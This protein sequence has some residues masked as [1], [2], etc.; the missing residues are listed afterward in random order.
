MLRC[1]IVDDSS[2]FLTQAG[3]L[4]ESQGARVVGV[5]ATS[6]EAIRQVREL[7]PDVTLLD[8]HLGADSGFDLAR[9]LFLEAGV[10][11]GRMILISS[12]AEDDYAELIAESPVAGFLSKSALSV[13]RIRELMASVP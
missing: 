12:A 9:R 3:R 1:V 8:L 6:E 2:V 10:E 5:A 4:L 7:C 13:D 11:P